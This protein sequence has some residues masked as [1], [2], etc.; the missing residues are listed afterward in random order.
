MPAREH[1]ALD[2]E[3]PDEPPAAGAERGADAD[4]ALARA[5]AREQQVRDVRARDQQH[6]ADRAE[7]HQHPRLRARADDVIAQRP[8]ADPVVLVPHRMRL[9]EC[10]GHLIHL[11][12]RLRDGDARLQ[13]RDD[14]R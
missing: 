3:L 1:E 13:P 12:L 11:R 14:R 5:G 2:H 4:L 8:H 7:Q 9:L 6:D 10:R